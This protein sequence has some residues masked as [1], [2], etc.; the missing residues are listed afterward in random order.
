MATV[1]EFD[2]SWP[3]TRA[4]AAMKVVIAGVPVRTPSHG[5]ATR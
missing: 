5:G 4:L 2:V 3:V 1:F